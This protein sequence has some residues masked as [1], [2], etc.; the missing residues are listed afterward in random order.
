VLANGLSGDESEE[1]LEKKTEGERVEVADIPDNAGDLEEEHK[2]A[3]KVP[4]PGAPLKWVGDKGSK[5]SND[6]RQRE[7]V[8]QENPVPRCCRTH[9]QHM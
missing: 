9:I 6:I 3:V 4:D 8:C 5:K 2:R 1:K 7:H